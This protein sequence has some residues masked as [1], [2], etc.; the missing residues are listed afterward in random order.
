VVNL[1]GGCFGVRIPDMPAG[2][3]GWVLL[4]EG[5]AVLDA[6]PVAP[7]EVEVQD[8][9]LVSID[10]LAT[11]AGAAI[12]QLKR[13][14]IANDTSAAALSV[15]NSAGTA[16]ALESTGGDAHGL[17]TTG[18]GTGSGMMA[19][20]GPAGGYSNQGI[21]I[22]AFGGSGAGLAAFGGSTAGSAAGFLGVGG[23]EA[24]GME[25]DASDFHGLAI[26][27]DGAGHH[28][29]ALLG[30]G[31][32]LGD[33]SGTVGGVVGGG[34]GD[35]GATAEEIAAAVWDAAPPGTPVADIAAAV[36]DA[37]PAGT[38]VEDIATAVWDAA[39]AGT[40]LADIVAA[41]WAGADKEGYALAPAGLDLIATTLAGLPAN[42]RER[43]VWL[44]CRHD[45]TTKTRITDTH[46][47]IRVNDLDGLPVTEQ[48]VTTTSTTIAISN[49]RSPA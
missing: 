13:L 28:D 7:A 47:V 48:D 38:P 24:A 40:P 43:L 17:S 36:W 15:T 14:V 2:H 10:G 29:V 27:M 19:Q 1:G 49:V 33:L 11:L 34:G 39:P 16:M 3:A 45:D 25:L 4:K 6:L 22:V 46:S 18:S 8:A 37:A 41:V 20:G 5:A 21:G 9:N 44:C 42:F 32:I 31:D 12:L 30:S 35:G 26:Y 23:V